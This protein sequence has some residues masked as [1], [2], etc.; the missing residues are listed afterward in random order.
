LNLNTTVPNLLAA[1]EAVPALWKPVE[2]VTTRMR[3]ISSEIE[4]HLIINKRRVGIV[5]AYTNGEGQG[6]GELAML[7]I[8]RAFVVAIAI[9]LH[10]QDF[11]F[12]RLIMREVFSLPAPL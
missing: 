5:G 2:K 1:T 3:S 10:M 9:E 8:V 6:A 12:Q 11:V 4:L 7:T